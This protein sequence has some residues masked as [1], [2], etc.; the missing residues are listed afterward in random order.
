MYRPGRILKSGS[1]ADV[2]YPNIQVTNRAAVIDMTVPTPAWR[3]TTPWRT[4]APSTT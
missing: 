3:E 4:R 2:D 1:W